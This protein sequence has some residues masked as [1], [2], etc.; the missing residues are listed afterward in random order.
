M[1]QKRKACSAVC[2]PDGIYVFGGYDG[3]QYLKSVE[4][5]DFQSRKWKY[6]QDMSNSRCHFACCVSNDLQYIYVIGGY[7]GKPLNQVER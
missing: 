3:C 7:N 6:L 2:M 5:Y 1:I 4:K